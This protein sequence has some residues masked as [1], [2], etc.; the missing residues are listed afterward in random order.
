MLNPPYDRWT[1]FLR[2]FRGKC[3]ALQMF[4]HKWLHLQAKNLEPLYVLSFISAKQ[5]LEQ[6]WAWQDTNVQ[7]SNPVFQM[8]HVTDL[9][10]TWLHRLCD[11]KRAFL[12]IFPKCCHL[13][14]LLDVGQQEQTVCKQRRK[15]SALVVFKKKPSAVVI[16]T[17]AMRVCK[18]SCSICSCFS[19]SV[20]LR[21]P[22]LRAATAP[23]CSSSIGNPKRESFPAL[24]LFL[25]GFKSSFTVAFL[26]LCSLRNPLLCRADSAAGESELS[27]ERKSIHPLQSLQG[28]RGAISATL[29]LLA[30]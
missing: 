11:R 18:K 24:C 28:S 22:T 4:P 8:R 16:L 20:A 3:W 7:I 19:S 2:L 15:T 23:Q 29:K 26:Y 5:W 9:L 10:L 27:L 6:S 17:D 21:S 14:A 13:I 1:L 25:A 30:Q 12:R